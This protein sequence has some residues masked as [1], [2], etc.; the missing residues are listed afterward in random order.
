MKIFHEK[1]VVMINDKKCNQIFAPECAEQ[2]KNKRSYQKPTLKKYGAAANLT[3]ACGEGST[4]D[5]A[6]GSPT[7]AESCS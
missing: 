3:K 6:Y 5:A 1:G 2:K 7:G 4:Y